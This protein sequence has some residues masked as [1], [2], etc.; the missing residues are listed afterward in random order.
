MSL[1]LRLTQRSL[2]GQCP[3]YLRHFVRSAATAV[4]KAD[5]TT[6]VCGRADGPPV[7]VEDFANPNPKN[8]VS[9]GFDY[10]NK[11]EDRTATSWTFFCSV[12]LCIVYGG[13]VWSYNPDTMMRDWAQREGFLELRRREEEGL[14]LVDPNFIEPGQINLPSDEDLKNFEIII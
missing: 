3:L 6:D 7:T 4:A 5:K 11:D 8:W 10:E 9:Y 14:E 12:T 2:R 13:F 1:L